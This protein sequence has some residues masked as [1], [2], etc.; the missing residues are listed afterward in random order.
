MKFDCSKI[1]PVGPDCDCPIP[2]GG[3]C[4]PHQVNKTAHFVKLCRTKPAY[5]IAWNECR[6]P[7]QDFVNEHHSGPGTEL[8]Q[9]LSKFRITEK[10][11]N[12]KAH[13]RQMDEWGP[14]KCL[15]NMETIV[16]WMEMEAKKRGGVTSMAFTRTGASTLVKLACWRARKKKV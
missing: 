11:C 12:C 10:S 4:E 14:D 5:R 7:R 3:W 16:D 8:V 13:A 2:D 1:T 15:E 6:G 9:L